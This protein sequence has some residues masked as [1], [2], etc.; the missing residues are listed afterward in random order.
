MEAIVGLISVWAMVSSVWLLAL[1]IHVMC[2]VDRLDDDDDYESDKT[3]EA[4]KAAVKV[5]EDDE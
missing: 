4:L 5:L 2:Q 1:T 3:L